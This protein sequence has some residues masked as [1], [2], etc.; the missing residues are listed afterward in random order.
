MS[1]YPDNM[2]WK[3]YDAAYG[4]PGPPSMRERLGEFAR[5]EARH[6]IDQVKA[7]YVRELCDGYKHEFAEREMDFDLLVQLIEEACWAVVKS[8]EADEP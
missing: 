4:D 7:G 3:A 1:N 8:A 5:T 6:F 2:D